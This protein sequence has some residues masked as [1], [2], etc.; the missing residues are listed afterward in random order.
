[1]ERAERDTG[2]RGTWVRSCRPS[3]PRYG[4]WIC[5]DGGRNTAAACEKLPVKRE[6]RTHTEPP[7]TL[8]SVLW[9]RGERRG[10]L[11]LRRDLERCTQI[12]GTPSGHLAFLFRFFWCN[13]I[14]HQAGN[15]SAI[16]SATL[17]P[18]PLAGSFSGLA[19]QAGCLYNHGCSQRGFAL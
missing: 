18:R 7:S 8:S 5:F 15:L 4:V 17:S 13:I 19:L 1:M 9:V 11:R 12:T 2:E 14:L 10:C 3:K 16:P 6:R